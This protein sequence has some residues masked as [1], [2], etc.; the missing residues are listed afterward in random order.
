MESLFGCSNTAPRSCDDCPTQE[1]NKIVHVAFV[2]RGTVINKTTPALFI[3]TLLTAELNCSAYIIRNVSGEYDGG[4][5]TE[6]TGPGKQISRPLGG[7][8]QVTFTDFNYVGNEAFWNTFKFAAQNYEMY[9]FSDTR[10]W[11]V[12]QPVAVSPKPA[13]TADYQTFIEASIVIKWSSVDNPI[14]YLADVDGLENCQ[15]LFTFGTFVNESNSLA[16]ISGSMLSVDS[17]DTIN[18]YTNTAIALSSV[19]VKEGVLPAGITVSVSGMK[20]YIQGSSTVL[21]TYPVTLRASNACG[22]SGEFDVTILVE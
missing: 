1:R 8:H 16:S 5:I 22:V 11:Y 2:K 20:I 4:T 15:T 13:V 19:E 21:G 17:G 18:T 7:A 10:G 3:S 9:Y 12:N 6:G 14:S